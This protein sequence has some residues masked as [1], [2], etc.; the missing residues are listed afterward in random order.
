MELLCSQ[1]WEVSQASSEANLLNALRLNTMEYGL[2][3]Q[4]D[5]SFDNSFLFAFY[6]RIYWR[7]SNLVQNLANEVVQSDDHL[8]SYY[9]ELSQFYYGLSGEYHNLAH[10]VDPYSVAHTDLQTPELLNEDLQIVLVTG[11]IPKGLQ[12]APQEVNNML[13]SPASLKIY[14]QEI[15]AVDG[16]IRKIPALTNNPNK[17]PSFMR[18][19]ECLKYFYNR[20]HTL[21]NEYHNPPPPGQHPEIAPRVDYGPGYNGQ[22]GVNNVPALHS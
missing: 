13:Q 4:L 6:H 18:Q 15:N 14:M 3:R 9:N 5:L 8:N 20:V 19:L 11:L 7:Q 2:V 10:T 1:R 12:Q 16:V 21:L 17:T 22:Q